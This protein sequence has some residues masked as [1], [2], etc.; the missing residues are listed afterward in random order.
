MN[1]V[2]EVIQTADFESNFGT[3]RIA[4]SERGLVY[5][6]FPLNN[7]RGFSGFRERFA[8]GCITRNNVDANQMFFEQAIE[9]V[10]G[11]R[12]EFA[13][14]IDLRASSFQQ[15]IFKIVSGIRSGETLSYKDVAQ[16][17]G[18]DRAVRAVGMALEANPLAL[19]IPCHRV[20]GKGGKLQGYAGGVELKARLLAAEQT[21]PANGRLF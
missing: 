18:D 2:Q 15:K 19:V 1:A 11:E 5:L 13:V 21:G 17:S 20:V 7:G 6:G 12:K 9:F 3:V 16:L 10:M 4:S 14:P 8:P